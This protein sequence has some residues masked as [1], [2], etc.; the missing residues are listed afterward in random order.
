MGG[1]ARTVRT[2]SPALTPAQ[3]TA[4]LRSTGT[5]LGVKPAKLAWRRLLGVPVLSLLLLA[6]LLALP[7]SVTPSHLDTAPASAAV[8]DDGRDW[9]IG[10][11]DGDTCFYTNVCTPTEVDLGVV[12]GQIEWTWQFGDQ[13]PDG[14]VDAMSL[15]ITQQTLVD[16]TYRARIG[17]FGTSSPGKS[18]TGSTA[19]T[20]GAANLWLTVVAG[21][22]VVATGIGAAPLDPCDLPGEDLTDVAL[23][24]WVGTEGPVAA[25]ARL[26]WAVFAR[27][28]DVAGFGYW[29]ARLEGGLAMSDMARLWTT[30]PEWDAVYAGTDDAEFVNRVYANVMD[31]EPDLEGFYYW[32]GRLAGGL[33]RPELVLYFSDSDEFRERT[34]TN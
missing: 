34:G 21:E 6:A 28:P 33:S 13:C 23:G 9:T 15:L 8:C 22:E 18:G 1:S 7:A 31:R 11:Q 4:G 25:V 26:Y 2:P 12:D 17:E 19:A 30:V 14:A 20:C 32:Q 29:M 16:G 3:T 24:A 10:T 5:P 27:Q